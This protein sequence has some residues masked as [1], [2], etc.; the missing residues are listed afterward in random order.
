MRRTNMSH[1]CREQTCDPPGSCQ[2]CTDDLCML[3]PCPCVC[4]ILPL[5][6]EAGAPCGAGLA[7]A[8]QSEVFGQVTPRCQA[9]NRRVWSQSVMLRGFTQGRE[10][11][12]VSLLTLWAGPVLSAA[13]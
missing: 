9:F 12:T 5:N 8:E 2:P 11:L 13:L 3:V 10:S 1:V 7:I 4:A 6:T